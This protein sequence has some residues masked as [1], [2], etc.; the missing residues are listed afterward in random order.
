MDALP[1]LPLNDDTPF[2]RAKATG[3]D[4]TALVPLLVP[5]TV[6]PCISEATTDKLG[7]AKAS[8]CN[9]VS[10]AGDSSS[11]RL[12]RHDQKRVKRLELSTFSLGS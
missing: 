4:P 10:V 11:E 1:A 2:D 12:T 5:A 9:E 8:S 3:T 7:G 6:H